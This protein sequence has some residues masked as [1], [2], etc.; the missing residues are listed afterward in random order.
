MEIIRNGEV[1]DDAWAHVPDGEA[2]P[3]SGD[4]IVS[5]TRW[6]SEREALA[7]R[8]G[9]VGVRLSP[10]DE[11]EAV[12]EHVRE[13]PLIAVEFPKYTDG[14]GYTT[15]RLLRERYGFRGELRAVGEV[16]RDQ[17][18][19]MLRCGFDAYEL[20]RGKDIQGALEAFSEYSV[21]YQAA[22]DDPRPLFRRR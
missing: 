1:V 10:D 2:L 3:G 13:L 12:A 4:V 14:R 6:S 7:S 17:L 21:T 18:F 11:P 22:A 19:Y 9:R 20:K 16:L 5:L 15:G 8:Q